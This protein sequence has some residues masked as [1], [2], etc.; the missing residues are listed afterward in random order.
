MEF[1]SI[2]SLDELRELY[3]QPLDLA[4]NKQKDEL[5][6]LTEQYLGLSPFSI[7]S[8]VGKNGF[9]DC[10][11]RGDVPGFIKPL[12]KKTLAIPDRPGNNR[13]DSLGNI[14]ENPNVGIL[15]LVPGFKECLRINGCAK[16]VTDENILK[17]FE[18]KGKLPIS[19][20]IVT[21]REIYFHCEKAISR[22]KLWNSGSQ[23]NRECMPTFGR[24]LMEQIDPNKTEDE[25]EKVEKLIEER[26]KTMLY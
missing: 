6:R 16:I 13:L 8:T 25:I 1:E 23:V 4:V 14:V 7:I 19:V 12:N 15:V 10:S 3:G 20:I 9:L 5:D 26:L 18:Y 11:P 2:N 24:M 17:M 21:I 22:A